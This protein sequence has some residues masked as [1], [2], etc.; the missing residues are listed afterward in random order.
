MELPT[1]ANV[2]LP[3]FLPSLQTCQSKLFDLSD[4]V[5]Q[6][7]WFPCREARVSSWGYPSYWLK[8]GLLWNTARVTK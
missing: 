1:V 6:Y 4:G 5:S 8:V 7:A 2:P 3:S